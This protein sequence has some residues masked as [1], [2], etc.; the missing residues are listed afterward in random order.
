MEYQKATF[1]LKQSEKYMRLSLKS[2]FIE[3]ALKKQVSKSTSNKKGL[4]VQVF[5]IT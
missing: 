4:L 2:Y 3:K 1:E 5:K